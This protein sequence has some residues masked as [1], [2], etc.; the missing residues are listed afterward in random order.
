[1]PA[2]VDK[3]VQSWNGQ[4]TLPP[5]VGFT[6]PSTILISVTKSSLQV[7]QNMGEEASGYLELTQTQHLPK[8]E[9][10][11]HPWLCPVLGGIWRMWWPISY[12]FG[13]SQYTWEEDRVYDP[14]WTLMW[15]LSPRNVKWWVQS[16]APHNV[17]DQSPVLSFCFLST[18][19]PPH[20]LQGS[21][22]HELSVWAMMGQKGNSL[23]M[24]ILH[25]K[26]CFSTTPL[27]LVLSNR[28]PNLLE[29]PT[30]IF[31]H[32]GGSNQAKKIIRWILL[33]FQ[34]P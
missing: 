34:W 28:Q 1:M 5:V 25:F 10:L 29:V 33:L 6:F 27:I 19:L 23:D 15:K 17:P 3:S 24:A 13:L 32:L 26:G 21:R 30:L 22:N 11:P 18:P 4:S 16:S 20:F 2:W 12:L 31:P 7:N 8:A 9:Q 14:K